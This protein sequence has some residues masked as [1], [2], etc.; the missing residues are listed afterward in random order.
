MLL[1]EAAIFHH[2]LTNI[3]ER[4]T[5]QFPV[6]V[7][8]SAQIYLRNVILQGLLLRSDTSGACNYSSITLAFC[9][10]YVQHELGEHSRDACLSAF[11]ESWGILVF[12]SILV[13]CVFD[14]VNVSTVV[15]RLANKLQNTG[16][17]AAEI[18]T[19]TFTKMMPS[20]GFLHPLL[21][22]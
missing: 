2:F 21:R 10:L 4:K 8:Y 16:Q 17:P 7:F 18:H 9:P 12:K 15:D 19:F 6:T 11:T 1:Y 22:K 20:T 3:L 5:N 14:I 13:K